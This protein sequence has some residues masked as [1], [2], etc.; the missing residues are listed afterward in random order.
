MQRSGMRRAWSLVVLGVAL[1]LH[2][3]AGADTYD[4]GTTYGSGG[5]GELVVQ[6]DSSVA[7]FRV[8]FSRTTESTW[9]ED[10]LGPLEVIGAGGRRGWAV[11]A[12]D[13]HVK[14]EFDG[15]HKLETLE[16]YRVGDG[17]SSLCRVSEGGGGVSTGTLTVVNQTPYSIHGVRFSLASD[18][19]WGDDQ[20]G[21][22]TIP[23]GSRRSWAVPPGAYNVKVE[24]EGGH[25][26]DTLETY[27]VR[28]GAEILCEV[29]TR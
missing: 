1:G 3:C 17:D 29:A 5:T 11:P 12:G 8:R 9:G 14:I 7:I 26:L 27:Q 24:L 19:R 6:N 10:R 15:G 13:Y 2:G 18:P 4:D 23:A 22:E 21:V 16:V 20:L 25:T 28:S